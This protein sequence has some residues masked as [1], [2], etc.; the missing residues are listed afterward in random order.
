MSGSGNPFSTSSSGMT[1]GGTYP[2]PIPTPFIYILHMLSPAMQAAARRVE[3]ASPR[4][5]RV[6]SSPSDRSKMRWLASS[7][8]SPQTTISSVCGYFM[9]QFLSTAT[10][11]RA[12]SIWAATS[13]SRSDAAVDAV[14]ENAIAAISN[15][16]IWL[17]LPYRNSKPQPRRPFA[18]ESSQKRP[19]FQSARKN[20]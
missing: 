11:R 7:G 5:I 20:L 14:A 12:V 2:K 10:R 4:R 9:H 6:S 15:L 16:D 18:E 13:A 8:F 17:S 19:D 3:T 1:G